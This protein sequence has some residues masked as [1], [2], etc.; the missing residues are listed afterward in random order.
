[1]L[2]DSWVDFSWSDWDPYE[3]IER[4]K[5]VHPYRFVNISP[6]GHVLFSL[7]CAEM[8][9]SPKTGSAPNGDAAFYLDAFWAAMLARDYDFPAEIDFDDW[10][11]RIMCMSAL[12]LSTV[13]NTIY[14]VD[15]GNSEIG[16]AFSYHVLQHVFG[17]KESISDWALGAIR[18]LARHVPFDGQTDEIVIMPVE[19]LCPQ[20]EVPRDQF[21]LLCEKS[22]RKLRLAANPFLNRA[23]Q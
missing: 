6:A 9:M 22:M 18:N 20:R 12:T 23:D 4:D 10:E 14:G 8:V 7:G 21:P 3:V 11:G 2:P 19:L 5:I 17:Q 13:L 16:A 1:M 15:E